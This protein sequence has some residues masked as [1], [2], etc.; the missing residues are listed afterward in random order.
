MRV[1]TIILV[2]ALTGCGS[3][4]PVAVQATAAIAP[5]SVALVGDSRMAYD[6]IAT[7]C[8]RPVTNLGVPGI[9]T[10]QVLGQLPW[11]AL[12]DHPPAL[13][14]LAVGV[15]DTW[16]GSEVPTEP[17][18]AS[19]HELHLALSN[20]APVVTLNI[21]LTEPIG[22]YSG[23]FNNALATDMNQ[24]LRLWMDPAKLP[25]LDLAALAAQVEAQGQYVTMD[26]VHFT[27][28]FYTAIHQM[29]AG[30]CPVQTNAL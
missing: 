26:G 8:G 18:L 4:P 12:I 23:S 14:L 6:G 13:I 30:A 2:C 24:A 10:G 15:N 9:H 22:P 11:Q 21:A 5:G 28:A 7:L 29:Y 1:L 17:W 3:E 16:R 27:Q 20:L 19:F 25:W